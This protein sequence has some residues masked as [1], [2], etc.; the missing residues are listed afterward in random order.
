MKTENE[1][2]TIAKS[3]VTAY[4]MPVI[5]V[6]I[7]LAF[8]CTSLCDGMY[9]LDLEHRFHPFCTTRLELPWNCLEILTLS[10]FFYTVDVWV[11]HYNHVLSFL[12]KML[13]LTTA[14]C[15]QW[16]RSCKFLILSNRLCYLLIYFRLAKVTLNWS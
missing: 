14:N 11:T 1:I 12:L 16:N 10:L 4:L 3:H 6:E 15:W 8:S 5:L 13:A 2:Q 9:W 7:V